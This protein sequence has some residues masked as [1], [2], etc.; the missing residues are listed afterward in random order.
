METVIA[1]KKFETKLYSLCQTNLEWAQQILMV[2]NYDNIEVL[3]AN[4]NKYAFI[5]RGPSYFEEFECGL[6][7]TQQIEIILTKNGLYFN[8]L[9]KVRKP[10]FGVHLFTKSISMNL[11]N[12]NHKHIFSKT[13]FTSTTY[14]P[15]VN[16]I[17]AYKLCNK[18][19]E[20]VYENDVLVKR[21]TK[22]NEVIKDP[23]SNT[24]IISYNNE[25]HIFRS[26]LQD[27]LVVENTKYSNRE[28]SYDDKFEEI[29][30]YKN[31]DLSFKTYDLIEE[32][33]TRNLII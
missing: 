12:S 23:N 13:V 17:P 1:L 2:L 31:K 3:E 9:T 18:T 28:Y 21:I 32:K 15:F 25:D 19:I 7:C 6:Y 20:N 30:Y 14:F 27:G 29:K 26:I 24:N 22:N 11:V 16:A 4:E 8:N 10:K 5:K 33:K